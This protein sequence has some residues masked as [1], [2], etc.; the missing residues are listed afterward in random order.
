MLKENQ[1]LIYQSYYLGVKITQLQLF[2]YLHVKKILH[3]LDYL[4]E[5]MKKRWSEH[6]L[7]GVRKKPMKYK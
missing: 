5:V 1:K 3:C 2:K 4:Y 7:R 6:Y